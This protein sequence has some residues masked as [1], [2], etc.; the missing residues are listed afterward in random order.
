M[1]IS[2]QNGD[3]LYPL[4]GE[5]GVSERVH[6]QAADIRIDPRIAKQTAERVRANHAITWD[7]KNLQ[8]T[9]TFA[10]VRTFASPDAAAAWALDVDGMIPRSGTLVMDSGVASIRYM[11]AAVVDPPSRRVSGCSVL[12]SY[13]ATGGAITAGIPGIW[14]SDIPWAVGGNWED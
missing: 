14:S 8:N 2:L 5:D 4:A 10:T 11:E 6:S 9:I 3:T 13:T 7:R 1:R 12:L